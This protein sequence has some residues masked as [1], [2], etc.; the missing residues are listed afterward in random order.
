VAHHIPSRARTAL[1]VLAC[2]TVGS[3]TALA[4]TVPPAQDVR[5]FACPPAQVQDAG[6]IDVAGSPFTLEINCLAGYGI[7]SGVTPSSY[8][9]GREV[10]R[11]QMAQFIARLATEHA[12]LQLDTRD[13]G[14]T[15]IAGLSPSAR[16]AINGLANAGIV[17]GL[18][19]TTYG[20]AGQVKRDQMAS[21]LAR[22]QEQLGDGFRAG[23][24]FFADDQA[25]THEDNI[26]RIAAAGIVNGTGERTYSPGNPVTRQQMAAFVMRYVA[27]RIQTGD[28]RS[29]YA[30]ADTTRT[31]LAGAT[32]ITGSASGKVPVRLEQPATFTVP[33]GGQP[34]SVQVTGEGRFTGFAL[35]ADG[36]DPNRVMISGGRVSNGLPADHSLG[37]SSML[38]LTHTDAL[39]LATSSWEL[40]AGDYHLYLIA[41]G[42][43]VTVT[44]SLAGLSG[45][46]Q[47]SPTV[48]VAAD[49]AR[50][51]AR[52]LPQG[53]QT[54][55]A[56]GQLRG[57][58]LLLQL[59][60]TLH[61]PTIQQ[62]FTNCFYRG[63]QA[64]ARATYAPG[65]PEATITT[66]SVV[67][68]LDPT[69]RS[70]ILHTSGSWS[71]TAE[72][73]GQGYSLVNAG[74]NEH[75]DYRALWLTF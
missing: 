61:E 73:F 35:V 67:G 15:D 37:D 20:P 38:A 70:L 39:D 7:T 50:P 68:N 54:A 24:D 36:T 32:T 51:E 45:S 6:F 13:A 63:E 29:I 71:D 52:Y 25:N 65:C 56:P 60:A 44:L 3:G 16:D 64:T 30:P 55:G 1:A 33:R 66:S 59:A 57:S 74:I 58:G 41:D 75:V 53:V 12:G 17:N 26:N 23:E 48:P 10:L 2:L 14:F 42:S 69:A 21:F 22:L 4:A 40:P 46:T 31:A 49:V 18:T 43:P 72:T 19:P 11:V 9:P 34:G 47:L 5:Q 27:D 8:A 62:D 28:V